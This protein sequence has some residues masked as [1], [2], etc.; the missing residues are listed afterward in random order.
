MS[1]ARHFP[2]QRN[3]DID[4]PFEL[5][6]IIISGGVSE[7]NVYI[8]NGVRRGELTEE[9]LNKAVRKV[10]EYKQKWSPAKCLQKQR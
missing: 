2:G 10:L 5:D 1:C 4:S 6:S 9:R 8:A 3:V 7:A